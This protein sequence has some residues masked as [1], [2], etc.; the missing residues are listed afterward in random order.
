[1]A[2]RIEPSQSSDEL[3]EEPSRKKGPKQKVSDKDLERLYDN[4]SARILQERNDFFLPQIRDFVAEKKWV[5]LRPE[6]QRRHRWDK[7]KQSRLIESLLM[8]VPVPPVFLYEGELNRYEVMDGQQRLVSLIDFYDGTLTL[9]GLE[10]WAGL[11]GRTYNQL[12]SRLKRGLDRRR[13]S[14]VVLLAESVA[15]EQLS[16]RDIRRE[17][18]ER[19]N[20]GGTALNHQE[21]RNCVY[22]GA[23]ND[24]IIT[25]AS[26]PRFRTMWG[27]PTA[28]IKSDN[29][30]IPDELRD[31][32][33]FQTMG[34]C[35]IVLRFFA[36][37]DAAS[38]RGSVRRT[39]NACM[40]QYEGASKEVLGTAEQEFTSR[41]NLAYQAFG[42][43]AFMLPKELGDRHS[44]PLFDAIMLAVHRLWNDRKQLISNKT[45]VRQRL[46]SALARP[47][48]YE[49]IVGRPNTANAVRA[50]IDLLEKE[51]RVAI[52]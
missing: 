47:K 9:V 46:A 27:I 18:F 24:L 20:T 16:S 26:V 42:Q 50:R 51:F 40:E 45:A 22:A 48:N 44:R 5:N 28:T 25:L 14:A 3:E 38:I 41:L 2:K 10:A 12:P 33:L 23:F 4:S 1:M 49:I 39:L 29:D 43:D 52:A 13:I 15:P 11:N 35:Q 32:K 8:N 21:L 7:K 36:F 37:Q 17:V 19:L 30:R 6:Y 31:N 34:D